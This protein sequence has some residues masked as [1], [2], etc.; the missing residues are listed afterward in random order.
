[1]VCG[2]SQLFGYLNTS[3]T[4]RG[5]RLPLWQH[6]ET[7]LVVCVLVGPADNLADGAWA[8]DATSCT[9]HSTSW[10]ALIRLAAGSTSSLT[11]CDRYMSRVTFGRFAC[12]HDSDDHATMRP[13][14]TM[15][16]AGEGTSGPV[17][18]L[19]PVSGRS[20]FSFSSLAALLY[21]RS[22][23]PALLGCDAIV[24]SRIQAMLLCL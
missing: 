18:G 4:S 24:G 19:A 13:T 6:G 12:E 5:D 15:M 20:S 7:K 23:P 10:A 9:S 22:I 2:R 14:A 16:I 3:S 1:M 11:G 21:Q 17:T 8:E